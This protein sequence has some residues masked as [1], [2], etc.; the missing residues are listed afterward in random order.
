[1]LTLFVGR[2]C[3]EKKTKRDGKKGCSCLPIYNISCPSPSPLDTYNKR[4]T[5][6]WTCEWE[7]TPGPFW[8]ASWARGSGSLTCTR[9]TW[10]W[11]IRWSRA[12]WLGK[13]WPG[14]GPEDT[15]SES[16]SGIMILF[17]L[18]FVFF[19]HPPRAYPVAVVAV[20]VAHQSGSYFGKDVRLP[21]RRIRGG[22]RI[23]GAT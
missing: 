13:Y 1:M 6:L 18:F 2:L 16:G 9:V 8:P 3:L 19:P 20:V 21:E 22:A 15:Q 14:G 5:H 23:R 12:A 11:P 10:S 17:L 7:S 4:P